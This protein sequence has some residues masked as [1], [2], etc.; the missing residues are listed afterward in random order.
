MK[1]VRRRN[2]AGSFIKRQSTS[3]PAPPV[4]RS[5]LLSPGTTAPTDISPLN[6]QARAL[7]GIKALRSE[8]L[9]SEGLRCEG[10]RCDG[11]RC[12]V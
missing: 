5:P 8:G 11:V 1:L 2:S 12:E 9:T 7:T 10:L 3:R 4:S 6:T